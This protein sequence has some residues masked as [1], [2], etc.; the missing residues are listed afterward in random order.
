M[1]TSRLAMAADFDAAGEVAAA[2]DG[3]AGGDVDELTGPIVLAPTLAASAGGR[4]RLT[5]GNSSAFDR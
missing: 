4:H 1:A 5:T 3:A 2:G